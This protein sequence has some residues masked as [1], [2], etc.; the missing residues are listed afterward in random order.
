MADNTSAEHASTEHQDQGSSKEKL[1]SYLNHRMRIRCE[2][3]RQFTGLFKCIDAYEN[4]IL[5]D[6]TESRQDA[7]RNVGMIMVP[8]KHIQQVLVENLEYI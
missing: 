8:G 6:T 7:Q 2:D 5:S 1:R 3:G 4:I